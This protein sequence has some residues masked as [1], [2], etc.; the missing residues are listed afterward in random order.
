[1][2]SVGD[3]TE[4]DLI[5]R[6]QA[7]LPPAPPWLVVG[8]GD[9]AAVIEPERNRLEVL[10]VDTLVESV[11][12]DRGFVPADAIGHRA[13][14]VNLSDL[15]AMG[16]APRL[17]LLAMALPPALALADFDAIVSGFCGLAARHRLHVA[18]GNLTRT[19]GPLTIDVTVAGT[20][21]RRQAL[22]R[23]GAR[24]GDELYVSGTIGSAKAGLTLLRER[25]AV[26]SHQSS[27]VS[28]QSSGSS[29]SRQ[30]DVSPTDASRLTTD[31]RR[32]TTAYLRP[33]PR[34]RLG[35]WLARN[36]VASACIDLSDGLADGVHRIAE[37]SGVGI[38]V[39]AS[40]LPIDDSARAAFSAR[41]ADVMRETVAGGDDY[42]LLFTV[43]RRKSRAIL[44]AAQHTG[45]PLTRIGACTVDRAVLVEHAGSKIPLPSVG[46]SHFAAGRTMA[47]SDR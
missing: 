36:R 24:P 35:V 17:A 26:V 38:T 22:T 32:L 7:Q 21:K 18:G 33:E 42:E 19:P 5:A 14:A 43:G 4:S 16:A 44:A 13:L 28:P 9:D 39:D 47:S 34:V 2:R 45:V 20:V 15:A 25:H 29:L 30:A 46:F 12:F 10:S 31:D 6:I 37:A 27:G 23:A 3:L 40:A 41:G 1:M 8:I 11:H